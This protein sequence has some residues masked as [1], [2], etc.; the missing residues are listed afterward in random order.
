MVKI[1]E[2]CEMMGSAESLT[3]RCAADVRFHLAILEASGNEL[4][5]PLGTLID[6]AL[7]RLFVLITR[8]AGSLHH[9]QELHE[10]IE[11]AIR[12]R[13]PT[14]ARRAVHRL[15]ANSDSMVDQIG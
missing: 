1:T 11:R 4:L 15:L 6:S 10:A 13:S 8:E 3:E 9:A 14:A 2:A 5:L 12:R 7:N